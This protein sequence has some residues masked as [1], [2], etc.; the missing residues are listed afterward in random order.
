MRLDNILHLGI[1]EFRSLLGDPMLLFLII[2]SFTA[3]VWTVAKSAPETLS[4]AAIAIV[5]E[6]QSALSLRIIEAFKPP[7]F[8]PPA[9]I[10]REQMDARLDAGIDTFAL[11]IP[12]DFQR[13]V[14]AGRRPTVQLNIDATRV[15]QA[16]SGGGYVQT[17]AEGEINAFVARNRSDAKLPVDLAVR[18]RFN[19]EL[20]RY[21]FGAINAVINQ[22]TLLSILLC[23]AALIREREQ[24]NIE[25]LLAMPVT[26]FEIMSGKVWSMGLVVLAAC[27]FSLVFVVQEWLSVPIQGSIPLF[28]A[29]A[30]ITLFATTSMGIFM[31]TIAGNLPQFGLLLILTILPLQML[32]GGATPYE[33]MPQVVQYL[34]LAAPT[35]HFVKLAQGVLF[36]GAG[37]DIVWPQFLAL[38]AIGAIFFGIAV[39]RF[40]RTIGTMGT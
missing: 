1:K 36:R 8:L 17:I 29:G 39:T 5:D 22:V 15:S 20:A 19:P 25:H 13:D 27:G 6:D 30:A 9:L 37:L 38:A 2:Y 11:D 18:V 34:M 26:P 10:T 3:S 4:N 24:G 28:L 7:Y 14:L 23:G 31:G 21:W 32:S 12:P 35:T 40:R 33:S 16:L